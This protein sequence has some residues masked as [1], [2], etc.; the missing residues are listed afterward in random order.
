[1]LFETTIGDPKLFAATVSTRPETAMFGSEMGER[2][3]GRQVAKQIQSWNL[4]FKVRDGVRAGVSK[5]GKVAWVA[6]NVNALQNKRPNAKPIPYRMFAVYELVGTAWK[7]V[8]LQF[9]TS[10]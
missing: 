4:I 5:S 8:H 7:L 2:Y 10:V 3:T 6:A 9:S 1:M